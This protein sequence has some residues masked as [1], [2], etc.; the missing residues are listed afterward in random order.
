MSEKEIVED[1]KT[2]LSDLTSNR[3]PLITMLTMLA[4]ESKEC[5]R[6]ITQAIL[7][8]LKNTPVSIKVLVSVNHVLCCPM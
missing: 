3:K 8:H 6:P 5:A 2:S 4:E 7:T 1:Y